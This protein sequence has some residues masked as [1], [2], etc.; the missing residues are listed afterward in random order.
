M[1]DSNGINVLVLPSWYPSRNNPVDSDYVQYQAGLLN[2]SGLKITVYFADLNIRNLLSGPL[3]IRS[4]CYHDL[5]DVSTNV[6]EGPFLPKNSTLSLRLW[7]KHYFD[8]VDKSISENRKFDVVHSHSYLGGYVA[9]QLKKKHGVPYLITEHYTGFVNGQ[10]PS[11]H[12]PVAQEAFRNANRCFAVSEGF[13]RILSQQFNL[14][15]SSLPNFID[16]SLFQISDSEKE[17]FRF[18]FVGEL[19]KRKQVDLMIRALGQLVREK[20][21]TRL[22]I[23]GEGPQKSNLIALAKKLQ[24]TDRIHF[25]GRLTQLEVTR[26]ISISHSLI[27]PSRLETF[28]IVLIEALSCGV[29]VICFKNIGSDEIFDESHGIRIDAQNPEGLLGA[30]RKMIENHHVFD[31]LHLRSHVEQ[32][33]SRQSMTKSLKAIYSEIIEEH[34]R[35]SN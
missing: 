26:E 8:F 33:F 32:N 1:N 28:G 12:I 4:R 34:K 13:S 15:F 7:L 23:V 3:I 16:T 10:I 18:V 11:Y 21:N 24:L 35:D 9:A 27:L 22:A 25:L 14:P 5:N 31:P 6:L 29:P 30:M 17:P 19:I 2:K 20:P